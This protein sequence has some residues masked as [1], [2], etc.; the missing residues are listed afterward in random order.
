L[1]WSRELPERGVWTEEKFGFMDV[2]EADFPLRKE[3]GIGKK[4]RTQPRGQ[5]LQ[6][7]T[8]LPTAKV[9]TGGGETA[10][11]KLPPKFQEVIEGSTGKKKKTLA[12]ILSRTQTARVVEFRRPEEPPQPRQ[13]DMSWHLCFCLHR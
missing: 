8:A 13:K 12:S 2:G 1:N 10:G 6:G 3:S 11:F 4:M 5:I 9:K 7:V